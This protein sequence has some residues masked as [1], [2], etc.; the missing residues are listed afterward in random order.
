M[1]QL[2]IKKKVFVHTDEQDPYVLQVSAI[3]STSWPLWELFIRDP[4]T[5][6]ELPNAGFL[7]KKKIYLNWFN[8]IKCYNKYFA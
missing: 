3:N 8:V 6:I 7:K 1:F 5:F 4:S 2:K